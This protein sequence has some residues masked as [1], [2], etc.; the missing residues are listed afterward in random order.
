MRVVQVR[1]NFDTPLSHSMLWFV[2]MT[3]KELGVEIFDLGDI[4]TKK[5]LFLFK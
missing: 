3:C 4:S 2:I 5:L 1:G